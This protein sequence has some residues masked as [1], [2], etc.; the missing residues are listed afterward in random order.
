MPVFIYFYLIRRNSFKIELNS[1]DHK[2][3][4]NDESIS[5]GVL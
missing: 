1:Y 2:G 5:N 4:E 3:I